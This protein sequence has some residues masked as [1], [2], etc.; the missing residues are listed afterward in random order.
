LK[1]SLDSIN[2]DLEAAQQNLEGAK[3]A[4]ATADKELAEARDAL[5]MSQGDRHKLEHL[6][7][8]VQPNF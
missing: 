4:K 1:A 5:A 6:S 7:D 2:A 3:L 8:E